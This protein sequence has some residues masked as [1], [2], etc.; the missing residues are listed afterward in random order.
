MD[1]VVTGGGS[2][3]D[4]IQ[5]LSPFLQSTVRAPPAVT[6]S[7]IGLDTAHG[8]PGSVSA[9]VEVPSSAACLEI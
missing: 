8:E 7:G 1:V 5:L 4:L 3:A 9:S 6:V 2:Y